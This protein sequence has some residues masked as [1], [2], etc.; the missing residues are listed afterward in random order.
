MSQHPFEIAVV[1]TGNQ[2]RSPIVEGLVIAA[3]KGL[4]VHIRSCGTE[5]LG[6]VKALPEAVAHA[7]RFGVD[8]SA[9]RSRAMADEDLSQMDLVIGFELTHVAGAV[10]E[11]GAP[12]EKTFTI[13]EL[14]DLLERVNATLPADPVSRA[15]AAVAEAHRLRA[16]KSS[17]ATDFQV[18]DP[19]GGSAEMFEST[20]ILLRDRTARL[21]E[22]LF[23]IGSTSP[24][25]GFPSRASH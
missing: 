5:R 12:Y 7:A 6:Q 2:F 24:E 11:A 19:V 22:M 20:A 14:G 18:R 21:V 8:L 13:L 4:P 23:G 25:G 17:F 3:V 9:H 15:R 16:A 1:C 10:V